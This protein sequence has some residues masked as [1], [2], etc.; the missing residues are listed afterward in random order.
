MKRSTG[1]L[2]GCHCYTGDSNK[3]SLGSLHA[4]GTHVLNSEEHINEE[5]VYH[6]L[7]YLE[8]FQFTALTECSF[9]P[10]SF[11]LVFKLNSRAITRALQK[12]L[13]KQPD[14]YASTHLELSQKDAVQAH[15]DWH[16]AR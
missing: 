5:A 15:R 2:S 8:P 1:A 14:C 7:Q 16:L 4:K 3:C 12:A 9:F 10:N 6:L 13:L 11:L